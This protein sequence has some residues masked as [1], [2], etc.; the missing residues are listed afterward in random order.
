MANNRFGLRTYRGSVYN[1]ITS[2]LSLDPD[3]AG[4]IAGVEAADGQSLEPAVRTAINNFVIGLKTDGIWDSVLASC[5]MMGARTIEGAIVP[6]KGPTPTGFNFVSGDYNRETGILGNTSTK[7]I[8][9][10]FLDA[11]T[12]RINYHCGVHQNTLGNANGAKIAAKL[13]ANNNDEA[14][15]RRNN[16]TNLNF[17]GRNATVDDGGVEVAPAFMIQARSVSATFIGHTN[18]TAYTYTRTASANATN[19]NWLLYRRN[20][21]TPT[22]SSSRISFYTIGTAL[23]AT[24]L[25]NYETR[26]LALVAAIAAA[27]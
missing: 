24:G 7:Y 14:G 16:P 6:L 11:S 25:A 9:T 26:V 12:Y 23:D 20:A 2:G 5:I 19:V 10:G 17:N 13:T 1:K 8:D 27:I 15:I 18:G 21:A 3:A 22:Y 4:Y